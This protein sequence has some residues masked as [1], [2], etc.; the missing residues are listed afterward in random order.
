MISQFPLDMCANLG[1]HRD[2]GAGSWECVSVAV[3]DDNMA[4]ADVGGVV[5]VCI[6]AVVVLASQPSSIVGLASSLEVVFS[7]FPWPCWPRAT[8]GGHGYPG[9]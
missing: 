6:L 3:V 2:L 9:A 1:G 7:I 4:V 5:F 8:L